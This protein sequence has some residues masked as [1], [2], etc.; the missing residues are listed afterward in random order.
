MVTRSRPTSSDEPPAGEAA[1]PR[2][3][4]TPRGRVVEVREASDM[5]M[6]MCASLWATSVEWNNWTEGFTSVSA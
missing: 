5:W 1:R 6:P 3:A 2:P 4:H